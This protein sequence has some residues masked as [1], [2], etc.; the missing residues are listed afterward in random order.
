MPAQMAPVA[1]GRLGPGG[2]TVLVVGV[3]LALLGAAANLF[4]TMSGGLAFS[5][6]GWCRPNDGSLGCRYLW[7][8]L[9]G[10]WVGLALAVVVGIAVGHRRWAR[11][12]GTWPALPL[13]S[14][15]YL[16]IVTAAFWALY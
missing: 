8:W 11:G 4:L 12:R 1:S 6:G 5:L 16:P 15:L 10:P 9:Y 3:L 2:V 7:V 13:G 14:V